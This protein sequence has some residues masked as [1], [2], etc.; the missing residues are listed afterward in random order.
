M[1]PGVLAGG[2]ILLLHEWSSS[3]VDARYYSF[4]PRVIII[5]QGRQV[6]LFSSMSDHHP[7]RT[8]GTILLL[9]E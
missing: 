1:V 5:L 4:T 9:H 3:C 7:V 6:P 2:T 8:P